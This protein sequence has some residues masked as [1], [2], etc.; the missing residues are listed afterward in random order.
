MS[1]L[2]AIARRVIALLQFH[3]AGP[4][5]QIAAAT[6]ARPAPPSVLSRKRHA[7]TALRSIRLVKH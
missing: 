4:H 3:T 5:R 7:Y 6:E 2:K 1:I